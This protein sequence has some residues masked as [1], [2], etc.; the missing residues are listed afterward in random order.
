MVESVLMGNLHYAVNSEIFF[1]KWKLL[2][3]RLK[4]PRGEKFYFPA[5]SRGKLMWKW[6]L[7]LHC[8][9]TLSQLSAIYDQAYKLR[10]F[11]EA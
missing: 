1:D 3:E 2:S 11:W 8:N 7:S 9:K 10:F 5:T 4:F 6:Q